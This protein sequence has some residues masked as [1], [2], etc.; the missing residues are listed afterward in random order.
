MRLLRFACPSRRR[1]KS[2]SGRRSTAEKRLPDRPTPGI[3]EET[4]MSLSKF[5]LAA[6]IVAGVV[7]TAMAAPAPAPRSQGPISDFL[8]RRAALPPGAPPTVVSV[9]GDDDHIT[10][11]HQ[12]VVFVPVTQAVQVDRDGKTVT[13]VR[14]TLVHKVYSMQTRGAVKDYKVFRVSK[15]GKLEALE[16]DKA[17]A[18]WKKPT[19]ALIGTS[20]DV[21]PRQ[22][23]LIKPGALYLV[24]PR[25]AN[26]AEVVPVPQPPMPVPKEE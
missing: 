6:L 25:V 4:L 23:E 26:M 16:A 19:E 2:G 21:D 8:P 17:A 15:E 7:L 12:K 22:L 24:L 3:E 1:R 5:G 10:M 13:E 14:T 20:A 18:R 9:Q 11:T